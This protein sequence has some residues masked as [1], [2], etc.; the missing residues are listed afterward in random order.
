MG[1]KALIISA[2]HEEGS[3][4]T[5]NQDNVLGSSIVALLCL[6]FKSY[7]ICLLPIN[8]TLRCIKSPLTICQDYLAT[9]VCM[10]GG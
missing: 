6:E 1:H 5:I 8:S 4:D 2:R 10:E 3:A 7:F 9:S